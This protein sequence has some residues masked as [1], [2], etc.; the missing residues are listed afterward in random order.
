VTPD[1]DFLVGPSFEEISAP[2]LYDLR[3][4]CSENFL[5]HLILQKQ[6]P[7]PFVRMRIIRAAA[8]VFR[9]IKDGQAPSMT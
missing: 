7:S 5:W 9:F 2:D 4:S 3:P 1:S 8:I 6:H